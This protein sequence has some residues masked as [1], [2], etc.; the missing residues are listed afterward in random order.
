MHK[1]REQKWTEKRAKMEQH[2][3]QLIKRGRIRGSIQKKSSASPYYV[4]RW[5]ERHGSRTMKKSLYLGS[6]ETAEMAKD[7]LNKW[8]AEAKEKGKGESARMRREFYRA[9]GKS[10]VGVQNSMPFLS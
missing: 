3:Q 4:L 9:L 7:L 1:S 6:E 8:R 5:R 2:R 10:F